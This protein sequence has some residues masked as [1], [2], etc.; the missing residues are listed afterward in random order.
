M[1]WQTSASEL[2]CFLL[3]PLRKGGHC[4]HRN[5][6]SRPNSTAAMTVILTDR[7]KYPFW[8]SHDNCYHFAKAPCLLAEDWSVCYPKHVRRHYCTQREHR[9]LDR[10]TGCVNPI[11]FARFSKSSKVNATQKSRLLG[12]TGFVFQKKINLPFTPRVNVQ[13]V[14]IESIHQDFYIIKVLWEWQRVLLHTLN[15]ESSTLSVFSSNRPPE[16]VRWRK[17]NREGVNKNTNSF[18]SL[19]RT[20]AV[21]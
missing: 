21:L 15:I 16:K 17:S 7:I 8:F 11:F 14:F 12:G 1:Y 6:C 9:S 13:S 3:L 5:T 4:T 10:R 2:L 19:R 20:K 18:S